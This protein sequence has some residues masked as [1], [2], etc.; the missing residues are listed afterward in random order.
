MHGPPNTTGSVID[1]SKYCTTDWE[2]YCDCDKENQ[3]KNEGRIYTGIYPFIKE[4]GSIKI[5]STQ[6]LD[7]NNLPPEYNNPDNVNG[8]KQIEKVRLK[9]E[10]ERILRDNIE[11]L[12]QLHLYIRRHNKASVSLRASLTDDMIKIFENKNSVSLWTPWE[13]NVITDESTTAS[14]GYRNLACGDIGYLV[15]NEKTIVL[16]RSIITNRIGSRPDDFSIQNIDC[17]YIINQADD[18]DPFTSIT[19]K[20]HFELIEG[21]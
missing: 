8:L 15:K 13:D 7:G 16:A 20:G 19:T 6:I 9:G 12:K 18:S 14:K 3:I 17:K 21:K 10:L 5:I 11:E 4:K 2:T 1:K